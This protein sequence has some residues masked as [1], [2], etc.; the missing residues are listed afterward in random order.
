M[1]FAKPSKKLHRQ[2][3]LTE[4]VSL[5]AKDFFDKQDGTVALSHEKWAKSILVI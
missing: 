5:D 3:A 2:P 1:T 4:K